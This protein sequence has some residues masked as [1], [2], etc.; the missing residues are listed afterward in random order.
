M[1]SPDTV[2]G[3][4]IK[5]AEHGNGRRT[6]RSVP[7]FLSTGGSDF[8]TSLDARLQR[9]Y[10]ITAVRLS[11]IRFRRLKVCQALVSVVNE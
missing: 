10:S 4:N 3:E 9:L 2:P 8:D 11:P 6:S 5:N 7:S 1:Q